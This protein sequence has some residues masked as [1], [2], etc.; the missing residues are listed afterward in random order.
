MLGEHVRIHTIPDTLQHAHALLRLEPASIDTMVDILVTLTHHTS[1]F[2]ERSQERSQAVVGSVVAGLGLRAR[3]ISSN[4]CAE[5]RSSRKHSSRPPR[6]S[7]K[8]EVFFRQGSIHHFDSTAPG[9]NLP[10]HIILEVVLQI[11]GSRQH[12]RNC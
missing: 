8:P 10:V 1:Q 11:A 3:Y 2:P 5:A 6:F 12:E 9:Y 4:Y 7:G